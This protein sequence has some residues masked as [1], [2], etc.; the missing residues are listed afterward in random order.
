MVSHIPCHLEQMPSN[1]RYNV[2][3]L[4]P[5]VEI[6]QAL[7]M[8]KILLFVSILG[9]RDWNMLSRNPFIE[10]VFDLYPQSMSRE[11]ETE[12]QDKKT[13]DR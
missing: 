2:G 5:R 8:C 4:R 7:D 1:S 12:P 3:F 6:L 11:P 9:E 10:I 13:Y